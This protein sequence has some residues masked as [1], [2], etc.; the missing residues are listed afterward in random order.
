MVLSEDMAPAG[1]AGARGCYITPCAA[2][3]LPPVDAMSATALCADAGATAW[4]AD[5]SS[6]KLRVSNGPNVGSAAHD[7][8][9]EMCVISFK[10]R[11]NGAYPERSSQ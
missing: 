6:F 11:F 7:T 10:C 9:G 8:S 1:L 3:H 4:R 2:N 5:A